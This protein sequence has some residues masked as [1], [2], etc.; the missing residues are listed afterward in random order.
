MPTIHRRRKIEIIIEAPLSRAVVA[1]LGE[2]GIKGY[3]MI[4]RVSGGGAHGERSTDDVTRVFENVMILAIAPEA[5]ARQVLEDFHRR[6]A[7]ATGIVY[8]S[9][10]E[11]ARPDHF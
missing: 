6:F 3:S 10:V 8:L 5:Q 2:L 7:N 1:W 4:P 11:V 9:D